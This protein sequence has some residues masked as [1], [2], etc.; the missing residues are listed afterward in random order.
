[1]PNLVEIG[2]NAVEICRFFDFSKMAAV[3]HLGF[4]MCVFEP[5]TKGAWWS[6]SPRSGI[7]GQHCSP[8]PTFISFGRTPTC[9]R[10]TDTVPPHLLRYHGVAQ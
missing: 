2:Q 6:L 10:Q 5:P 7:P 8:E 3:R 4:V 9:D 1:V